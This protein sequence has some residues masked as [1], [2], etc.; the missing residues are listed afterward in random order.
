MKTQEK[1]IDVER[2]LMNMGLADQLYGRKDKGEQNRKY[3]YDGE[4]DRI[5]SFCSALFL[6]LG[7]GQ[8][9]IFFPDLGGH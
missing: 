7:P 6:E 3:Y 2:S 4:S 5:Y 1:R 9:G 8:P